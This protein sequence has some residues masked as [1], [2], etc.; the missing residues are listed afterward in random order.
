MYILGQVG[1]GRL[2]S[3]EARK[4]ELPCWGSSKGQ[5]TLHIKAKCDNNEKILKH[6]LLRYFNFFLA[7]FQ[8]A[9]KI[10]THI[11]SPHL[12]IFIF[13]FGSIYLLE[14]ERSEG[15][16]MSRVPSPKSRVLSPESHITTHNIIEYITIKRGSHVSPVVPQKAPPVINPPLIFNFL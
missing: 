10:C 6:F 12:L 15:V 8:A 5:R 1:R 9:Q 4:F 7:L 11:T 2:Q 13:C 14:E 3:G 16:V